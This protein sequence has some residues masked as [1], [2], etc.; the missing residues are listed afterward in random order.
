M[1]GNARSQSVEKF[2]AGELTYSSG[3]YA[4]TVNQFADVLNCTADDIMDAVRKGEVEAFT[5]V[6]PDEDPSRKS[7]S[8][9]IGEMEKL[10]LVV[11]HTEPLRPQG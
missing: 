3:L 10:R 6:G 2:A 8:F 1:A 5:N 9:S 4:G 7:L 11:G